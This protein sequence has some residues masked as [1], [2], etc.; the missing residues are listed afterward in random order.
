[1]I[2]GDAAVERA[3]DF[4]H[5]HGGGGGHGGHGGYY[6]RGP[7][8]G[9][10]GWGGWYGDWGPW[11]LWGEG[12]PW[13]PDAYAPPPF[14][15]ERSGVAANSPVFGF[16]ARA[17]VNAVDHTRLAVGALAGGGLL[18]LG[19]APWLAVAGAAVLASLKRSP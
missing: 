2:R 18:I 4:G 12:V 13:I 14:G 16:D 9:G 8:G 15:V 6:G 3:V 17:M 19:A 1:M 7:W 11:G 10:G 5:G